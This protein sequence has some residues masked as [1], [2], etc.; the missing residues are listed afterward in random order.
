[1]LPVTVNRSLKPIPT[2]GKVRVGLLAG[3]EM[4]TAVVLNFWNP[5]CG[6]SQFNEPHVKALTS[7]FGPQ[8]VEFITVITGGSGSAG[9][10]SKLARERGI[11]GKIVV[12]SEKTW[13]EKYDIL[14]A[15]AAVV[16]DSSGNPVYRGSYNI[17]RLCTDPETAYVS[18]TLTRLVTG[19][20]D[21]LPSLP[22][23]GCS[24]ALK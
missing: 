3:T 21:S 22:F 14:A 2:A 4:C 11:Q 20:G 13:V 16:F 1:M 12:D 17:N 19:K 5:N 10:Q 23:Y 8:G 7:E 6:C 18:K 9:A 24:N 15:P